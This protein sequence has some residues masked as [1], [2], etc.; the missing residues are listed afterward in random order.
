MK[1]W[2]KKNWIKKEIGSKEEMYYEEGIRKKLR[3]EASRN[4][5]IYA[6]AGCGGG[7]VKERE[8]KDERRGIKREWLGGD[9][10]FRIW[11]RCQLPAIIKLRY[12]HR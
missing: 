4:K 12:K 5:W 3:F 9:I 2:N 6:R 7:D 10:I 8:W 11:S 1:R